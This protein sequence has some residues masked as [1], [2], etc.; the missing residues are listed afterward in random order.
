LNPDFF[1]E[2]G[3]AWS[4]AKDQSRLGLYF[5]KALRAHPTW[6]G[7]FKRLLDILMTIF[8]KRHPYLRSSCG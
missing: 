2:A 8:A 4:P 1:I 5:P 3:Q 6:F 7:I